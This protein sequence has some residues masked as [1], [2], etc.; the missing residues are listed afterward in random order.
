MSP[1]LVFIRHTDLGDRQFHHGDELPPG[2]LPREAV[3]QWLDHGR[4]Q[5]HRERRSLYRLLHLFSG[6][7]ETEPLAPEELNAYALP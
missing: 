4:L 1:V 7:E 5:E 6:C 2:L 3:D